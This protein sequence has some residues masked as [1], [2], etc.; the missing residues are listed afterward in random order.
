METT[1]SANNLSSRASEFT[2]SDKESP[3]SSTHTPLKCPPPAGFTPNAPHISP[4]VPS[5]V[6]CASPNSGHLFHPATPIPTAAVF[7]NTP[8]SPVPTFAVNDQPEQVNSPILC[9]PTPV[10]TPV[11]PGFVK[12][13][14][15]PAHIDF[16]SETYHST[17]PAAV[18]TT[19]PI[20]TTVPATLTTHN[21]SSPTNAAHLSTLKGNFTS[22]VGKV[23]HN[24][25]K[26][27]AGNAMIASRKEE[28]AKFF[29]QQAIEWELKGGTAKAM[30]YREKAARCRQMAQ[31]KLHEPLA[32]PSTKSA[33][34]AE[35]AAQLDLKA[36]E[37]ERKG[38]E[39]RAVKCHNK[40]LSYSR[41][42]FATFTSSNKQTGLSAQ[43][44]AWAHSTHR[45]CPS[46]FGCCSPC[47][48]NLNCLFD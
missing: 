27:Q 11:H 35:K 20:S 2:P 33:I 31:A 8:A 24:P 34:K 42:H 10:S 17:T 22:F 40:V 46:P 36:Q 43:T 15:Q 47:S 5:P 37:F 48:C 44:K 13:S 19:A 3:S 4:F 30:K 39:A 7:H 21:T 16:A 25:D 6:E 45:K 28:K 18:S 26:Q 1:T 12:H 14:P 38:E 9:G 29:E 23:T 32:V 41:F